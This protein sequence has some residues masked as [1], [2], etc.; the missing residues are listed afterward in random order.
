MSVEIA[1]ISK[2]VHTI[3]KTVPN[4]VYIL[5]ASFYTKNSAN[6]LKKRII[7]EAPNYNNK[8]LKIKKKSSKEIEV[9]SGPYGSINLL[10]NDYIELKKFGFEELD[11]IIND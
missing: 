9:I 5:I 6:F 8:M 1:N 2:K 10:K 11:I 7:D 3:K 4:N